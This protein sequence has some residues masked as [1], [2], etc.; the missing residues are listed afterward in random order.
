[1]SSTAERLRMST[2]R[3]SAGAPWLVVY[4]AV[5]CGG[6]LLGA[7]AYR[8]TDQF[9]FGLAWACFTFLLIG[10]MLFPRTAL[11]ATIA[12]TLVG[13]QVT[14]WWFPFAKNLS[15]FESIMY[16][17]DSVSISPLEISILWGL[18][19]TAYRNV[20]TI[21]RPFRSA[22]LFTPFAVFMGFALLGLARGLARGGDSRAALFEF[23]PLLLLA[24]AYVLIVNVCSSTQ[25]YRRMFGVALGAV[26]VQAV[27]SLQYLH[28]LTPQARDALDSLNE[29][30][31]AI[32]MNL[33]LMMLVVALAYDSISVR[34]R[35]GLVVGA[36]PVTWVY[37]VA[38]RRAA[39]VSLCVAFILFSIMLFWRQRRTFWRVVPV[40]MILATGYVGALWNS[41]STIGFPAQAVKSVIAPDSAS[42][43][44][45]SSD[46]Y[47]ILEKLNL[48]ATV[49]SSPLFGI[50]FGQPFLR[51][52]SLPDISVFEFNAYLPHNSLIWIWIKMGFGGFVTMLYI[53]AR[54]VADGTR[55]ARAAPRG[56]DAVVSLNAVLFVAMFSVF[57]YVDVG[58][59]ARNA[60]LLALSL[61]LCTAPLRPEGVAPR[62]RR[63]DGLLSADGMLPDPSDGALPP[64]LPDGAR[65]V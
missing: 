2:A 60:M 29:H 24:F 54:A 5:M 32:G 45:L 26:V 56:I 30:G 55:R 14:V 46:T 62:A 23:R 50:G 10:W 16:L 58:W 31:S 3:R 13:D 52:Y 59:E 22:P 35:L 15:S 18:T 7:V 63:S 1:M 37:L 4:L 27:L 49:K 38:Q 61:G 48:S 57:L 40:V 25:D 28:G 11:A 51:Q 34:V 65:T 9:Y 33:L 44:D 6:L 41:E 36:L 21:G 42:A 19:V 64:P 12:L 17:A 20:A 47:R 53:L 8:R 39:V 43:E